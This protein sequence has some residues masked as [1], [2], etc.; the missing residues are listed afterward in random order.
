M[1]F[2]LEGEEQKRIA[3]RFVRSFYQENHVYLCTHCIG[4][5]LYVH[6]YSFTQHIHSKTFPCFSPSEVNVAPALSRFTF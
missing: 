3:L 1:F 5:H 6:I 2:L 4:D